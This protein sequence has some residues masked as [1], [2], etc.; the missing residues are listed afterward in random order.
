MG[1]SWLNPRTVE[2]RHVEIDWI[3][4]ARRDDRAFRDLLGEAHADRV[5]KPVSLMRKIG[6]MMV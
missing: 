4:A 2:V 1:A 3:L 6:C 5:G